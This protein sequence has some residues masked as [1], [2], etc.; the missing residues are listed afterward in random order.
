MSGVETLRIAQDNLIDALIDYTEMI[1]NSE[2]IDTD[3]E[4]LDIVD[5]LT[6]N[7]KRI[8]DTN[9][10]YNTEEAEEETVKVGE[11]Q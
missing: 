5:K 11:A 8:G 2:S 6:N 3:S 7:I 1:V 9:A 10:L 4:L